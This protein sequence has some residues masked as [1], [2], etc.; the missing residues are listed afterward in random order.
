M[1]K[2]D[3]ALCRAMAD[4]IT[5]GGGL[6][7]GRSILADQ[8]AAAADLVPLPTEADLISAIAQAAGEVVSAA[9]LER[10]IPTIDLQELVHSI[11]TAAARCLTG[12]TSCPRR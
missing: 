5:A 8:L 3:P 7:V 2:L 11:A 10:M 4:A 6:S 12:G 9:R 1:A